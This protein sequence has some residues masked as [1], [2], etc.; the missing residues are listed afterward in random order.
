MMGS[1]ASLA[2]ILE[3]VVASLAP[4]LPRIGKALHAGDAASA[5]KVLHSIKGYMPIFACDALIERVTSVEKISKTEPASVVL[6]LYT[7][8][9]PQLERLVAE[10]REFLAQNGASC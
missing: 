1:H 2:R 5:N 9:E 7:E 8:L 4:E 6:P 10:I 3:T